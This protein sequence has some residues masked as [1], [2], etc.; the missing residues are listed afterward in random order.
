MQTTTKTTG[1]RGG[2]RRST[3]RAMMK[4]KKMTKIEEG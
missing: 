2:G 3:M 1:C 4:E